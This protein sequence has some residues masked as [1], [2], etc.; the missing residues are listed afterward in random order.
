MTLA[1][2]E[3]RKSVH[4]PARVRA[5]GSVLYHGTPYPMAIIRAGVLRYARCGDPGISFSRSLEIA[6]RFAAQDRGDSEARGGVL[7]FN[8]DTLRARYRVEPFDYSMGVSC[9]YGFREESEEVIWQRDV[10]SVSRHIV[11]LLWV[12]IDR[13]A[14]A[15]A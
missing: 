5:H 9:P 13:L 3:S 14:R 11:G 12:E 8:R 2:D 10:T 7:V 4:A 15:R 6:K 1:L